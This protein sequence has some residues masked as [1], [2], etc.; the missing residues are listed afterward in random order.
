LSDSYAVHT[1]ILFEES[2]ANKALAVC[3]TNDNE[4]CYHEL[5]RK[6]KVFYEY[7]TGSFHSKRVSLVDDAGKAVKFDQPIPV[8]YTHSGTKSNSGNNYNEATMILTYEGEGNLYGLPEF[9]MDQHTGK[10][11]DCSPF[12]DNT[13]DITIPNDAI[14]LTQDGTEYVAKPGEVK[15]IMQ[16]ANMTNCVSLNH[17]NV[18]ALPDFLKDFKKFSNGEMP[19]VK[20]PLV[21]VAGVLVKD[22]AKRAEED[23]E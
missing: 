2:D 1:G 17:N 8:K 7:E 23:K 11:V 10:T 3:E 13:P 6:L 19:I 16:V 4:V 21:A 15:Q 12:S 20:D 18:P 22:L 9:C 5:R 14:L